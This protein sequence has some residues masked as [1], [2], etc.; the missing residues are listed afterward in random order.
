M[1]SKLAVVKKNGKFP[2][3]VCSAVTARSFFE[4]GEHCSFWSASPEIIMVAG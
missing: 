3:G 4:N 2:E 1:S